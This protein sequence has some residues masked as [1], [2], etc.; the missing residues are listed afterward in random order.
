MATHTLG[1]EL[2]PISEALHLPHS[3]SRARACVDLLRWPGKHLVP[4]A[5]GHPGCERAMQVAMIHEKTSTEHGIA[6]LRDDCTNHRKPSPAAFTLHQPHS[7]A[8]HRQ[9][10]NTPL[11]AAQ[12]DEESRQGQPSYHVHTDS[13]KRGASG[14]DGVRGGG[15]AR[16]RAGGERHGQ[17]RDQDGIAAPLREWVCIREN[18]R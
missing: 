18:S 8:N 15:G 7:L 16:T 5:C 3:S 14:G 2:K 17:A 13:K 11:V 6:G 12:A 1:G 10:A 9:S 4:A